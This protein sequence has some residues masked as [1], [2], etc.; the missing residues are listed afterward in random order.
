MWKEFS[1]TMM[2]R[3]RGVNPSRGNWKEAFSRVSSP[4]GG[5]VRLQAESVSAVALSSALV[6]ATRE[7]VEIAIGSVAFIPTVFEGFSAT[8]SGIASRSPSTAGSGASITFAGA[9]AS[10]DGDPEVIPLVGADL[11]NAFPPS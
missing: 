4:R 9:V 1:A 5:I 6:S 7:P 11:A 8:F 10:S 2:F 3:T